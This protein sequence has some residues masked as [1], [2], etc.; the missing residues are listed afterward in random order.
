MF[1]EEKET[2]FLLFFLFDIGHY[3]FNYLYRSFSGLLG[4]ILSI[5]FIFYALVSSNYEIFF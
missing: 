4:Y 2:F 5:Y 3:F 1:A